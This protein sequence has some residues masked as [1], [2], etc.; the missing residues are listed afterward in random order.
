MHKQLGLPKPQVFKKIDG[1]V[2][3]AVVIRKNPELKEHL[4]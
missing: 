4:R 3:E 1:N 2:F